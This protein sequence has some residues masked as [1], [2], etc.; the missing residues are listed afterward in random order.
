VYDP[1]NL[2]EIAFI[3][4]ILSVT[5][6]RMELMQMKKAHCLIVSKSEVGKKELKI[7]VTIV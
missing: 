1:G 5:T 6:Q 4:K 7:L 2:K 3:R